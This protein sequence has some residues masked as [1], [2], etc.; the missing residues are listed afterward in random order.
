MAKAKDPVVFIMEAPPKIGAGGSVKMISAKKKKGAVKHFQ[1][2]LNH[3]SAK[4]FMDS[5]RKSGA[6]GTIAVLFIP[7]KKR[8]PRATKTIR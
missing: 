8:T 5:P 6:G 2:L 3:P 4:L 1:T 7:A